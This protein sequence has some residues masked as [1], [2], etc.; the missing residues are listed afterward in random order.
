MYKK[1]SALVSL[2][3]VLSAAG[4][5]YGD[6]LVIG[7]FEGNIYMGADPEEEEQQLAIY[8]RMIVRQR[9]AIVTESEEAEMKAAN[10]YSTSWM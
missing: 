1:L 4:T 7:D 8:R 6:T 9:E 10:V 3:L 5:I 2:V